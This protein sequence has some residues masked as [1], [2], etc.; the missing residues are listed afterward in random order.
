MHE[1]LDALLRR[2]QG[3]EVGHQRCFIGMYLYYIDLDLD[4]DL[5]IYINMRV[6]YTICTILLFD[7]IGS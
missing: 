1:Q 5:Y 2:V 3:L 4:L 7:H 6:R